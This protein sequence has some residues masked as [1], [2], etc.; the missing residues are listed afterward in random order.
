MTD[1]SSSQQMDV[2]TLLER[3]ARFYAPQ[4][5]DAA[6][7]EYQRTLDAAPRDRAALIGLA[8]TLHHLGRLEEALD[9]W[10]H[11]IAVVPGQADAYVSQGDVLYDLQ[12]YTEALARY[13]R[14]LQRSPGSAL[15][16]RQAGRALL[17]LSRYEEALAAYA[18]ANKFTP[19]D[20]T[21]LVGQGLALEALGRQ[22]Q[23]ITAYER[24][25]Q[26]DPGNVEVTIRVGRLL[27]PR[28]GSR[29]VHTLAKQLLDA[30]A[31]NNGAWLIRGEALMGAGSY[32]GALEAYDHAIQLARNDARGYY[33]KSRALACLGRHR[34][35]EIVHIQARALEI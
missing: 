19:D 30:N 24:A 34:E 14:A 21:T 6:L 9:A 4:S 10:Q 15:A 20:V 18:Q 23:A 27:L 31:R 32:E 35:A 26:L 28:R 25:L 8:E 33:G 12:R 17:R 29:A 3:G 7:N 11:V 1:F 5:E 13:T 16:F 22:S 2:D